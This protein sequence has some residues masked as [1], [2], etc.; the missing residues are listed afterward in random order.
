MAGALLLLVGVGIA[1]A[2][3]TFNSGSGQPHP[4]R[5]AA[6]QSLPATAVV[7]DTKA[8]WIHVSRPEPGAVV[9][10]AKETLR[11]RTEAGATL[12]ITDETLGTDIPATVENDGSFTAELSLRVGENSFVLTSEDAA[13]NTGSTRLVLTRSTSL[14]SVG[15][16]VSAH[17]VAL[18]ALP[19]SLDARAAVT[20]ERGRPA[21]GAEVTFSLSP[22]NGSTA[23]YKTTT[24]TGQ[25]RWPGMVVAGGRRAV[26]TWLVTV[27]VTLPSGEVL[28]GNAS[29]SVR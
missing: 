3:N 1:L 17:D 27:L 25:A 12:S 24:T 26:G 18:A 20:D 7:A 4:S 8:P 13:S 21:E 23:T 16:T 6:V 15:L 5:P 22:P 28:R 14:G 29:F 2:G 9:Y 19:A 10:G 11:G